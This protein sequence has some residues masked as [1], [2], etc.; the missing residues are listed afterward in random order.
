MNARSQ[1]EKRPGGNFFASECER[2]FAGRFN[3][4]A[5]WGA[6]AI[7]DGWPSFNLRAKSVRNLHLTAG[8]SDA[9]P[10]S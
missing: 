2:P 6:E 5:H 8:H 10:A 4:A 1:G 9:I 7:R 3:A